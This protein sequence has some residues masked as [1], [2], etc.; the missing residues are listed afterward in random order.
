LAIFLSFLPWIAFLSLPGLVGVRWSATIAALLAVA[1]ILRDQKRGRLKVLDLK[2]AAFFVL[3]FA[4]SFFIAEESLTRWS[5]VAG[6]AAIFLIV[7]ATL[8]T[9][10]PFTTPY[11]KE[12]TPPDVWDSPLFK[13]ANVVISSG[14]LVGFGFALAAALAHAVGLVTDPTMLIAIQIAAVIGPILF[15]TWY[16]RRI[17][18]ATA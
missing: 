17:E 11:A 4:A 18:R 12:M 14:W 13:R 15:Q 8:L 2:S 9:G 1:M 5:G 7:L 3:F 16:R 10:R 6:S